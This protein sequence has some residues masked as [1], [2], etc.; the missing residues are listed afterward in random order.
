MELRRTPLFDAH[1][2]RDA[3]FTDFGGWEMPVSFESIKTEHAAVREDVGLFDVSHM[4]EIEVTGPDAMDLCQRLVTNDVSTLA[5]GRARYAA[6]TDE[7]G[8]ILDDIM[9]YR[10]AEQR[11]LFVPNAGKDDW[12]ADRWADHRERWDY[13]AEITNRTTEFGM[14]ALQGPA[15]DT[16]LRDAGCDPDTIDRRDI[17]ESAVAGIECFVAGTGYT[18]ENGYELLV[19]WEEAETV[20]DAIEATRCGLGARDTLRLEMGYLLA[21]N[22]FDH[23]SNPRTPLEARISFAVDLESTP[24]FVGRDVLAEQQESGPDSLLVGIELDERGVPRTGYVIT[25][26]EGSEIGIVTSGTMSPSLGKPIGLGYV[27]APFAEPETGIAVRIR[28]DERMARIVSPP[29]K[30]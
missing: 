16:A 17:V 3:T 8:I 24:H 26:R 29:F 6:V 9:I 12:M 19:P 5:V 13:E 1:T 4:G 7:D 23:E 10:L 15:A 20:D 11:F 14:L 18:G 25:D 30:R 27:E 21:G 2:A 28:D 22:E